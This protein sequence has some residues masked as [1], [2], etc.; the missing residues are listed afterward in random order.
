MLMPACATEDLSHTKASW[1]VRSLEVLQYKCFR[2]TLIGS[3]QPFAKFSFRTVS[4][5]CENSNLSA[6]SAFH[7]V[8]SNLGV[9]A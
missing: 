7:H 5:I 4:Q 8:H 6:L 2:K 1:R 9:W 3:F